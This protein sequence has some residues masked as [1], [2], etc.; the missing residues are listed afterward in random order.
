MLELSAL[1]F[2]LTVC[3]LRQVRLVDSCIDASPQEPVAARQR[4]RFLDID[5]M[6]HSVTSQF[7]DETV[8]GPLPGT[9]GQAGDPAG[10][11][12]PEFSDFSEPWAT[13]HR[14]N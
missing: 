3:R 6:L 13:L 8:A 14:F 12:D 2:N 7:S 11:S 9:S 5:D 1:I 4:S 10:R